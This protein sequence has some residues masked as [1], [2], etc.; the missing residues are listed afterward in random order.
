MRLRNSFS[1]IVQ[2]VLQQR[3][4]HTSH[5]GSKHEATTYVESHC[6][7][8]QLPK[9]MLRFSGLCSLQKIRLPRPLGACLCYLLPQCCSICGNGLILFKTF[10]RI[11][12]ALA[13]AEAHCRIEC[14]LQPLI[15]TQ[16]CPGH[17]I[18]KPLCLHAEIFLH[19]PIRLCEQSPKFVRLDIEMGSVTSYTVCSSTPL[20]LG[21]IAA[22]A[23]RFQIVWR[24]VWHNCHTSQSGVAK[25]LQTH[26]SQPLH[27]SLLMNMHSACLITLHWFF[28]CSREPHWRQLANGLLST[29]CQEVHPFSMRIFRNANI[30]GKKKAGAS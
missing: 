10:Q 1:T 7:L 25:G 29:P 14:I 11:E 27:L 16:F 19:G 22:A 23:H 13:G 8:L 20:A 18:I 3:Q 26:P 15:P 9:E 28:H 5:L 6:T 24:T 21:A 30:P 4:R 17:Q 2:S 12:V